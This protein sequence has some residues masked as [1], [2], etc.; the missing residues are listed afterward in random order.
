MILKLQIEFIWILERLQL[1]RSKLFKCVLIINT[2]MGILHDSLNRINLNK[3]ESKT[4]EI[5]HFGVT[6]MYGILLDDDSLS[7]Q[8]KVIENSGLISCIANLDEGFKNQESLTWQ[9]IQKADHTKPWNEKDRYGYASNE[10][11]INYIENIKNLLHTDVVRSILPAC[12]YTDIR[13][14]A[15]LNNIQTLDKVVSTSVSDLDYDNLFERE[16]EDTTGY[17]NYS[18]RRKAFLEN[19]LKNSKDGNI[20]V[21]MGLIKR[22]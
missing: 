19:H 17:L 7:E 1:I 11:K 2:I 10:N 15:F 6:Y 20:Q 9:V 22:N 12:F 16:F 13:V 8:I 14:E 4:G 3:G 18:N 21:Y 5:I